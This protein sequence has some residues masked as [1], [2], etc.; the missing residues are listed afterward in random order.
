MNRLF[1]YI[2]TFVLTL[3]YLLAL[4]ILA[5]LSLKPKYK[6]SIPAR[7]FLKHNNPL[8]SNGVWFH[9][10]SFGEARAIKPFI[11]KIAPKYLRVTATTQTGMEVLRSYSPFSRYLPFESLLFLWIRPQKA[12]IVMEA[13]LWYLLFYLAKKRGSKTMLINARISDRSYPKY[14][15]FKWIYK[16][17]FGSVDTIFAQR[18]EDK[19]RLIELGAKEE[20][21][22]VIGNI[23]MAH[24]SVPKRNLSKPNTLF[25]CGASTHKKEENLILEAFVN[26][27][28][29]ESGKL[30]LV[31][32]HPER[33]DE[34]AKLIEQFSS[35]Y[36]SSWHRFSTKED[37]SSDIILV[38][39]LGWLVDIYAIA[40]VVI[41]GGAFEKIGGHN[42]SEPAQFGC[43]IISG[44]H[45][46]N[47]ADI[48]KMID[49]I[50]IVEKE[51]LKDKLL[52]FRS[53]EKSRINASTDISPIL[54]AI[55]NVL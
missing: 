30:I 48:F 28:L 10:C 11:D 52:D 14:K 21:I 19:I 18:N 9:V 5:L 46:F 44:K 7:F 51:E 43:R 32:R 23:K 41:L 13:E 2:Y 40:D 15:K 53:I 24:L 39:R 54:Q 27:R 50:E 12:L 33:F 20:S 38:D 4:P 49:G 47:Q 6:E 8:P 22:E 36:G 17:I 45:Y 26:F 35:K 55:E 3:G 1:L 29:K 25:I 34:V 42:A 37:F 16:H 31:P